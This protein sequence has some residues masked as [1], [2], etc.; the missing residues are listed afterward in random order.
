[1]EDMNIGAAAEQ[2]SA[3]SLLKAAEARRA[4]RETNLFLDIPSWD[5][6][7]IGEYRLIPSKEMSKIAE[8][9]A[10][11]FKQNGNDPAVGDIAVIMHA[12]VGLHMRDPET[13]KRVPIE[14]DLG[15]VGFNR[16]ATVLGKED[17]I[18]SNSDAVRYLTAE[19]ADDGSWEEN[20]TAINHHAQRIQR[21]MRDPSKRTV[22][23]EDL[24]SELA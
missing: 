7:M 1:M 9:V 13:G 14:D 20:I 24:L 10:R 4:Q 18:K 21:W 19:R 6:D 2:A 16:I 11:K 12:C 3:T 23:I 22:D 8:S 15:I 17:D 5:G